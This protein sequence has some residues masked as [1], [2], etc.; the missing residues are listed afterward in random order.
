M[1]TAALLQDVES[2]N[3]FLDLSASAVQIFGLNYD[4]LTEFRTADN[5]TVPGLA[6]AWKTASDQKTWTFTIR[7]G[8]HWS[9]GKPLT[10]ADIAFTYT[11]IMN[12][13]GAVNASEVKDF[14]SVTA[15]N[16]ET[17]VITTKVPTATMLAV[18]IP[19]VPAHVW[20]SLDPMAALQGGVSSLVGS[21]PFRLVEARAG[22]QYRLERN[23]G[24]W[25]GA[26]AMDEV[27]LRYF[28][29]SDAAAQALRKG[30]IDVVGN[31]TPAQFT[32][33]AK[34]P[35]VITNEAHGS[36]YTDLVF[37]VGAAKADGTAIGDGH[38]ALRDQRVRSA[39]EFAIDRKTLVDRVLFGHAEV[40]EAYFPRSYAPWSWSPPPGV[41]RDFNPATANKMLDDAGYR[42]GPDGVRTMPPGGPDP[43]RALAFRLYAPVERS[44]YGQSARYLTQWLRDVGIAVETSNLTG[45][46][47]SDRFGAGR[48]D[49]MLGGWLLDPDPDFQLSIQTCGARPD[50][51][52]NGSTNAYICDRTLDAQYLEQAHQLDPDQR[53]RL[54]HEVQQRLYQLA[55][56]VILYYPGVLEAYRSDRVTNLSRRPA[57]TGSLVGAWSYVTA[58]PVSTTSEADGP[59]GWSGTERTLF[60]VVVV[61]LVSTVIVLVLLRRRRFARDSLE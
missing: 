43:G 22:R 49:L 30:E 31:L 53:V 23:T 56:Q 42:R 1:L 33:L 57:G 41:R 36:R 19:I 3:P 37:N 20:R 50:A 29:N 46:Q 35:S 17:L 18:D 55:P 9:D 26:P 21:G 16:P 5:Q 61:L 4:R 45:S 8:V 27:I 7:S 59:A 54:V 6:T 10:A 28:A 58:R 34:E 60:V 15:P 13:A 47:I 2:L 39:I 51:Q 14:S 11:T 52:G 12:H 48:Y 24:Y 32:A 44:H 40:G 38:P 25:R